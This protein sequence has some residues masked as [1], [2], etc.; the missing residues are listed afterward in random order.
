MKKW[1]LLLKEWDQDNTTFTK[2]QTIEVDA[3][4]AESLIK[5]KFAEETKAPESSDLVNKATEKFTENVG[6]L[7]ETSVTKAFGGITE[8]LEKGISFPATARDAELEKMGGFK[9]QG[10]FV[11]AVIKAA[12]PGVKEIDERL[13]K[14]PS[15]QHTQDDAEGGYLIPEAV[16]TSVWQRMADDYE[17]DLFSGAAVKRQTSGNTLTFNAQEE[18]SRKDGSRH[19]GALAYWTDEADE[20]TKS[21]IKWEK[22]RLELHKLTALYY[23]TDEEMADSAVAL[24]S[25]FDTAARASIRWKL[26]QAIWAGNGIGKPLGIT[27]ANNE[28]LIVI[29][30]EGSQAADTILHQNIS[31][32]YHRMLPSFRS[33]AVWFVHPNLQEQLEFMYFANDTTNKRPLYMPANGLSS[34]PYSTL[35][36]R[37]VVPMEFCQDLGDQGDIVFTDPSQ[38]VSL[39]KNRGGIKRASSIHVRFLYEE[40]AFRFSFR[41]DAQP[42]YKKQVEDLNGTTKRSPYITLAVRA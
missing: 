20:F 18:S 11:N 30:K 13:I 4:V 8:H 17:I 34:S 31:K 12:Q 36:G 27:H 2:G 23:A 39:T 38:I 6:K 15:G 28:A 26:N 14:A 40:T 35:Y 33:R 24:G 5:L 25:V 10:E 22:R 1:I 16:E 37:P 19:F 7:I 32:M 3:D 9:S 42:L 21:T 29:A 41:V